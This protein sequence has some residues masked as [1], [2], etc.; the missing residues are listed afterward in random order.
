M[1]L[2]V[3]PHGNDLRKTTVLLDSGLCGSCTIWRQD[4]QTPT[5]LLTCWIHGGYTGKDFLLAPVVL[6]PRENIGR[7]FIIYPEHRK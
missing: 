3:R 1:L 5:H 2:S 4:G 7:H 6:S